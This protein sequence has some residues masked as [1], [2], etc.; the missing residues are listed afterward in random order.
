[1]RSNGHKLS[2]EAWSRALV[3]VRSRGQWGE[4]EGSADMGRFTFLGQGEFPD[5]MGA[6]FGLSRRGRGTE[7]I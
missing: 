7:R 1:M 4:Q 2:P 3:S 6:L 5:G